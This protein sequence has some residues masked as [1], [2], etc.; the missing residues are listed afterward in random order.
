MPEKDVAKPAAAP[1]TSNKAP[2]ALR[3]LL[4]SIEEIFWGIIN[5]IPLSWKYPD[6]AC[7]KIVFNNKEY[8]AENYKKTKWKQCADIKVFEKKVGTIEVYY[9]QKRWKLGE[10]PFMQKERKL[11]NA[12]AERL[13]KI[14]E[15]RQSHEEL[16]T[17]KEILEEAKAEYM[18]KIIFA[19][20]K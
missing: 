10:K 3:F 2:T 11:I 15:S 14:I 7:G 9:L 1:I 16:I 20:G 18:R 8:M 6:I 5:L 19:E 13:G 4:D 12:I 17:A